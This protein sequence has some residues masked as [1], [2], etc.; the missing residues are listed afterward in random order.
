MRLL[1]W[2]GVTK[3]E[4]NLFWMQPFVI[5]RIFHN[6][7]LNLISEKF[8]TAGLE[9]VNY[10]LRL[11]QPVLF[12]SCPDPEYLAFA[13]KHSECLVLYNVHDRFLDSNDKWIAGHWDLLSRANVVLCG[14]QYLIK[15]VRAHTNAEV[16]LFPPAVDEELF[17]DVVFSQSGVAS[18]PMHCPLIGCVGNLGSQIDW[19]LL[20]EL[21]DGPYQFIFAGPVT[22][23]AEKN[24]H[25]GLLRAR[26]NV[27]FDGFIAH[28]LVPELISKFD[29]CILPYVLTEYTKGINPLKLFEFLALGK[30]VVASP[31]PEMNELGD[32]VQIAKT[33]DQWIKALELAVVDSS[34]VAR[35]RRRRFSA[36]YT[37]KVRLEQLREIIARQDV[38]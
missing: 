12:I 18:R 13:R 20:L 11:K 8:R 22:A 26:T 24:P 34:E 3:I 4:A 5:F 27:R 6:K 21:A 31:I 23:E 7:I 17:N 35:E 38:K 14:S 19:E 1:P 2:G 10:G 29:V 28:E 33:K 15:E 25:Y 37:Y 32:L 9:V 16:N 30:P 36:R